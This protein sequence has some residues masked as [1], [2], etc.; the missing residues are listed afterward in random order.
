MKLMKNMMVLMKIITGGH[1][2]S[3]SKIVAKFWSFAAMM[4]QQ[5][6]SIWGQDNYTKSVQTDTKQTG[7]KRC[8]FK[9][10]CYMAI[11]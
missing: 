1:Q 2:M 5:Y 3:A 10:I 11:K 8:R 6:T 9:P 7:Q 4:A